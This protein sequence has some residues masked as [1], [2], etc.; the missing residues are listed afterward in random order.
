VRLELVAIFDGDK[1]EEKRLHA[2][3]AS[4]RLSG[5]WFSRSDELDELIRKTLPLPVPMKRGARP[6]CTPNRRMVEVPAM[7][8][9]DLQAW[10]KRM[11]WTQKR[12]AEELGVG[13]RTYQTAEAKGP[14]QTLALH[15]KRIEE[16]HD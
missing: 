3:F 16:A 10:R 8:A 15:A 9:A 6:R 7:T 11:G 14:R 1:Y 13:F 2:R 4:Q 5:E 12:A